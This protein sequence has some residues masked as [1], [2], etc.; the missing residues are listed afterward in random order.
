MTSSFRRFRHLMFLLPV[1]AIAPAAEG[2][3]PNTTSSE[4]PRFLVYFDEFS[5]NLSDDAKR[6]TADAAKRAKETAAKGIVVQARASATGTVETNKYLAQT[7][8]SIVTD[9][10]EADGITR[11]MI[12]QE[13]IGQTGSSD[14]SVYNR[15]VDIILQ[16]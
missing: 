2:Q 15:R 4:L 10:L 13:P 7:R 6:V 16:R 9:Q 3:A 14:P 1:L 11:S 12:R 5:A 8:S